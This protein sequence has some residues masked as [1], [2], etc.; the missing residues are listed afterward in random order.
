MK[1]Q[2]GFSLAFPTS[3][4]Q[5]RR[6]FGVSF[7]ATGGAGPPSSSEGGPAYHR[8]NSTPPKSRARD[9]LVHTGNPELAER[10]DLLTALDTASVRVVRIA[11]NCSPWQLVPEGV[12][13]TLRLVV[14]V[15]FTMLVHPAARAGVC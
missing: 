4:S 11:N 5:A 8:G 2:S 3:T 6:S 14:A 10:V 9:A 13:S 1:L 12:E 7:Y 15:A